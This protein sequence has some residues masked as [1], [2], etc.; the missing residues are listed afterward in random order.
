VPKFSHGPRVPT[1][2]FH[3]EAVKVGDDPDTSEPI[4]AARIVWQ[5]VVDLTADEAIEANKPA[6]RD[7]R[8][9]RAAPAREFLC[10]ILANGPV[11]R[12]IVIERGAEEGF[13]ATQLKRARQSI[14]GVSYKLRGKDLNAPQMWCIRGDTPADVD[15]DEEGGTL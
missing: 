13:S 11:E 7:G 3:K 6:F 5:G 9:A 10:D 12:K 1:L 2:A 4:T 14:N 8:K 15:I